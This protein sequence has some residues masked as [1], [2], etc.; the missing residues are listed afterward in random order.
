MAKLRAYLLSPAGG[1]SAHALYG[2]RNL[3]GIAL[4]SSSLKMSRQS[5]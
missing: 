5:P 2:N 4:S 3:S 1:E